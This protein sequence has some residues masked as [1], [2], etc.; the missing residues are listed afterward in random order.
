MREIVASVWRKNPHTRFVINC[1][2]LESMAQALECSKEF[3]TAE[4]V[5]IHT[6]TSAEGHA[7]GPYTMMKGENPIYIIAFTGKGSED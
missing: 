3:G 2:A 5:E 1:I 6:V 4:S 7:V